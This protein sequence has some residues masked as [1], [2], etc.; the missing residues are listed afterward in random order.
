MPKKD[1]S[2]KAIFAKTKKLEDKSDNYDS[3]DG[4]NCKDNN[5]NGNDKTDSSKININRN[6]VAN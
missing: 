5:V 4:D 6:A 2:I 3:Q 1:A